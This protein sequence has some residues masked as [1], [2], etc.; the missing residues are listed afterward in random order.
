MDDSSVAVTI[1]FIQA[2][3]ICFLAGGSLLIA[4][5]RGRAIDALLARVKRLEGQTVYDDL[6]FDAEKHGHF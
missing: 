4:M 1:I 6:N 5:Y 3:V 2:F